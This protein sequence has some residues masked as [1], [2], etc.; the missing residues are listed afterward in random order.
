VAL[1]ISEDILDQEWLQSGLLQCGESKLIV[2]SIEQGTRGREEAIKN[3]AFLIEYGFNVGDPAIPVDWEIGNM[4]TSTA[5]FYKQPP[6]MIGL[7]RL[8]VKRRLE[9]VEQVKLHE[10]DQAGGN[11]IRDSVLIRIAGRGIG[12]R[13][14]DLIA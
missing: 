4:A 6:A 14:L 13:R 3:T 8:L 7:P 5:R 11:L 2:D 10:V 1:E 9:V 12:W